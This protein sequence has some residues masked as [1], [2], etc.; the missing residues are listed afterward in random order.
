MEVA[1]DRLDSIRELL[2]QELA[3]SAV[4]RVMRAI[5][6]TIRA[7]DVVA[8]LEDGRIAVLLPNAGVE[9]AM[10]VAQA[11]RSAIARAGTASTT[12][13]TLSASIGLATYPD[14]AHDVATLRA[15]A[16]SML[17][18]AREQGNDQLATA[19]AIPAI[20][21]PALNHRVG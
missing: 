4:E 6:A 18:Q 2:G 3:E 7:S 21:M 10:K 14:H 13:P 9:N 16:S 11:I 20:A 17:T 15:A 5:K 8:R 1:V 12:M 19:P